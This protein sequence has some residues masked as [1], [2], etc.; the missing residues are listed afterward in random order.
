MK[1]RLFNPIGLLVR[2]CMDCHK[3]LGFKDGRGNNGY[4]H[5]LCNECLQ[6][7]L[8]EEGLCVNG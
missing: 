7:R 2:E 3:R 6:I 5:G 4:T 8:A 1:I